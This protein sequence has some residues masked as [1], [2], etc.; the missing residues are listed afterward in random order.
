MIDNPLTNRPYA[1][2]DSTV[3]CLDAGSKTWSQLAT[4]SEIESDKKKGMYR[5]GLAWHDGNLYLIGSS[6]NKEQMKDKKY[7][8]EVGK[9]FHKYCN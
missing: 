8:D 6:D 3:Y 9:L 1:L 7:L 2:F 5:H 4:S